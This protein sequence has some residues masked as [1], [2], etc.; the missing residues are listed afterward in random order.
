MR[1]KRKYLIV[2]DMVVSGEGEG[3]LMPS[4]KDVGIIAIGDNPVFFDKVIAKIMGADVRRIPSL[5]RAEQGNGN[6]LLKDYD[7]G[8]VLSNDVRWNHKTFEMLGRKEAIP[9]K[10]TD[11]WKKAWDRMR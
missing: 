2:A 4:R 6:L 3:P 1:I 11:G 7:A 10:P 9:Y 5:W 8:V